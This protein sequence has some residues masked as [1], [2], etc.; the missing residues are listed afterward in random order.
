MTKEKIMEKIGVM[1][2]ERVIGLWNEC[3]EYTGYTDDEVYENS[4]DFFNE[5]FRN[6]YDAAMRVAFGNWKCSDR[7]VV[8]NGYANVE[9][10]N[11][12]QDANSP[13]DVDVLA[14][15]LMDNPEKAAEIGVEDDDDEE[16]DD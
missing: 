13:V 7:Y 5:M 6:P 8:F 12:W 2:T 16:E 4:E 3:I 1:E 9:S 11:Y 15:W 10:F 14:E